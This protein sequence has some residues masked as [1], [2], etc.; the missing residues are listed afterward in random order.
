M[1]RK[2][3]MIGDTKPKAQ[4]LK[5]GRKGSSPPSGLKDEIDYEAIEKRECELDELVGNFIF[6]LVGVEGSS[7]RDMVGFGIQ[8]ELEDIK[9]DIEKILAQ[10][11]IFIYRPTI[12]IDAEGNEVLVDST[13]K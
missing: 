7:E 10:H 9:D 3:N 2:I 11:G 1:A 5:E 4:K 12:I 13:Y 8:D 6:D